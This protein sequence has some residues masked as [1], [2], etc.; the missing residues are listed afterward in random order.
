MCQSDEYKPRED[1]VAMVLFCGWR[2]A[3]A[4]R[5]LNARGETKDNGAKIKRDH[6][7]ALKKR[8]VEMI[9]M[10]RINLLNI[11]SLDCT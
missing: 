1:D 8:H 4:L 5:T 9:Q 3:Y 11:L 10:K 2:S 6:G 7:A